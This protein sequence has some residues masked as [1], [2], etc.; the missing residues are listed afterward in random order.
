MR[1]YPEI[2]EVDGRKRLKV[3]RTVNNHYFKAI[4]KGRKRFVCEG[5]N[6]RI[7][8]EVKKLDQIK[9]KDAYKYA[10]SEDGI[11]KVNIFRT[12][13]KSDYIKINE[14]MFLIVRYKVSEAIANWL[15]GMDPE[16]MKEVLNP[17]KKAMAIKLSYKGGSGGS[18]SIGFDVKQYEMP[19]LPEGF[20]SLYDAYLKDTDVA[21]DEDLQNIKYIINEL[22]A[23]KMNVFNPDEV[24]EEL[25]HQSTQQDLRD[26]AKSDV[27]GVLG[28]SDDDVPWD[29]PT[30]T[31]VK[32]RC[33]S[34]NEGLSFGK[35]PK[36]Q[37]MHCIVCP[38]EDECLKA[39][40]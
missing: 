24:D 20:S 33:P 16:D 10:R 28:A 21:S 7:C 40:K 22:I 15:A 34:A 27:E 14:P 8:K 4:A 1:F 19:V 13:A 23:R 39:S 38:I 36:E 5:A 2:I 3:V 11:I 26:K 6:C 18:A 17:S 30:D 9:L 32:E 35:H 25:G 31:S 29:E 37:S 12:D